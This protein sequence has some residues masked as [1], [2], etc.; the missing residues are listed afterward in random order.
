MQYSPPFS[1]LFTITASGVDER[2]VLQCCGAV[3]DI[4]KRELRG[5][6]D[7]NILGIAPL[8]VVKVSNRFRYRVTV[9]AH[10][11]KQVRRLISDI[12]IYCNTDKRFRGVS[13][14]AD[15]MPSE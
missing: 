10:G 4:L 7:V 12:L 8:P 5:R 15:P 2:Q 14:F 1:D 11:D 6:E 13:V 9:A 3:R